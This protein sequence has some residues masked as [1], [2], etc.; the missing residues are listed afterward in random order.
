MTIVMDVDQESI[1]SETEPAFRVQAD[2]RQ[3]SS[4][5]Q[6]WFQQPFVPDDNI[7]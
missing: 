7:R 3:V 4:I 1:R 6:G 5:H 2:F